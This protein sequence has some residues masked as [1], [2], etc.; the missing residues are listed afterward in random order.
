M[1]RSSVATMS[2]VWGTD[3]S[4]KPTSKSCSGF[5][6]NPQENTAVVHIQNVV[7]Q[8]SDH[9]AR[10]MPGTLS[11]QAS[12]GS[13]AA[14]DESVGDAAGSAFR[15]RTNSYRNTKP[16]PLAAKRWRQS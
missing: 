12:D 7:S 5:K 9:T 10:L 14:D 1:P 11:L 13:L 2:V 3:S 8:R 15:T 4:S 6:T 16:F